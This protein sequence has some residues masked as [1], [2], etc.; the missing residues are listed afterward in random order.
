[1]EKE[2]ELQKEV[3]SG[4]SGL[5][6]IHSKLHTLNQTSAISPNLEAMELDFYILHLS[7]SLAGSQL[8]VKVTLLK[9]ATFLKIGHLSLNSQH[10]WQTGMEVQTCQNLCH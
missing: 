6:L 2:K 9:K 5:G 1:M 3:G 4:K 8:L 7:Q 10:S